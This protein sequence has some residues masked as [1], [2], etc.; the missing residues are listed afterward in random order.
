M[1]PLLV[2][3]YQQLI[4]RGQA[5]FYLVK[6]HGLRLLKHWFPSQMLHTR[7]K[8]WVEEANRTSSS[9][10]NTQEIPWSK[11]WTPS[12]PWVGLENL[13]IKLMNRTKSK[14]H[15]E[16]VSLTAVI[17]NQAP[18]PIVLLPPLKHASVCQ[19]SNQAAYDHL[20]WPLNHDMSFCLQNCPR[21]HKCLPK[22]ADGFEKVQDL[23]LSQVIHENKWHST[24]ISAPSVKAH[25]YIW[26]TRD[27]I[28]RVA[29]DITWLEKTD[30]GIKGVILSNWSDH[31]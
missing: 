4:W 22:T 26:R 14:M 24:G 27:S 9:A 5:T 12:G 23:S 11:N 15:W 16:Q 8:S 21:V 10:K 19:N 25:S 7:W 28:L 20:L 31:L 3:I 13:S 18:A 30:R 1:L 29:M 2:W 6:N 17:V